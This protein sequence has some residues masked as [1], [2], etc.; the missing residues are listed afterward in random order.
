MTAPAPHPIETG[1]P[2]TPPSRAALRRAARLR[3]GAVPRR[4]RRLDALE[5]V[6]HA[7]R[8]GWLRPGRRIALYV[9]LDEEFDTGP[10]LARAARLRCALYLPRVE[11][12]RARRM[13]FARLAPAADGRARLRRNAWGIVEPVGFALLAPRW[14]NVVF[15]PTVAFDDRGARLGM[16]MGFYDRALHFRH[17]H[18]TS[19]RPL[20]VGVAWS[21]QRLPRVDLQPHDLH[22][23]AVLTELGV[24]TFRHS[25]QASGQEAPR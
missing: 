21:F 10:L 17:T 25:A 23:D 9:P 19:R 20:A 16:G 4:Q 24:T 7:T 6:K 14:L 1:A 13:V 11:N 5:I 22:L 18:A 8:A 2:D 15:V 12:V 3:R